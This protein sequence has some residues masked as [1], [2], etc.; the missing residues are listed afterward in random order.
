M[1][2]YTTHQSYRTTHGNVILSNNKI[3]LGINPLGVIGTTSE[4]IDNVT[5]Q[6]LHDS[7]NIV[8][9]LSGG[10]LAGEGPSESIEYKQAV[11]LV[12]LDSTLD[13]DGTGVLPDYT[14]PGDPEETFV[15][16]YFRNDISYNAISTR[17]ED[18]N[19]HFSTFNT[20]DLTSASKLSAK[21]VGN[22]IEDFNSLDN[23]Y[24]IVVTKFDLSGNLIWMNNDPSLNTYLEDSERPEF[25]IDNSGNIIV[26]YETDGGNI[27]G[28]TNI[29]DNNDIIIF[30]LNQNGSLIWIK[31]DPSWNSSDSDYRPSV[32][33]DENNNIYFT[34]HTYGDVGDNT[35]AGYADL[36]L[37][38]LNSDGDLIWTKQ[39]NLL[40]TY[41]DDIEPKIVIDNSQNIVMV[42]YTNAEITG[43]SYLGNYDIVIQKIDNN[44]NVLWS[45]QDI[46]LNSNDY[47]ENPYVAIDSNNNIFLTY[48]TY[49]EITEQTSKGG[50][51]IV[52]VKL[53]TNGNTEWVKQDLSFNTF[54]YD[55]RPSICIDNSD[56]IVIA[57]YTGENIDGGTNKG[58]D[59][60]VV[61][62]LNQNGDLIWIKQDLSFNT[63]HGD[64][65]PSVCVD[66][67]NNVYVTFSTYGQVIGGIHFFQDEPRDVA[68][69]KLDSNGNYLF[70][71]QSSEW[72]S[73]YET[74]RYSKIRF[75]NN[76]IYMVFQ[77]RG[78][79]NLIET[80]SDCIKTEITYSLAPL[81]TVIK[82]EVKLT[83]LFAQ[84]LN[85]VRFMRT[86]DNE[87][88]NN[89]TNGSG[90][91]NKI[92]LVQNGLDIS[93]NSSP[94]FSQLLARESYGPAIPPIT[95]TSFD[96]RSAVYYNSYTNNSY[97]SIFEDPNTNFPAGTSVE[98]DYQN[99]TIL[100]RLGNLAAG[101]SVC[102]RYYLSLGEDNDIRSQ[103][104]NEESEASCIGDPFIKPL[105]GPSYYLPND[106]KTHLLFDNNDNLQIYTKTW[107][108]PDSKF[109]DMSFM[110]NLIINYNNLVSCYDLELNT[111]VDKN[112][113]PIKKF[114]PNFIVSNEKFTDFINDYRNN[115]LKISSNN[116]QLTF[117]FNINSKYMVN[118][119]INCD[120][121][122]VDL[123]N[124]VNIE[125]SGDIST[126][127]IY[128]FNGAFISQKKQKIISVPELI[129]LN[130]KNIIPKIVKSKQVFKKVI[131]RN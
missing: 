26:V 58:S 44:G 103:L 22:T 104:L 72:N 93:G 115:K 76:A 16:S 64:S 126:E 66:N 81:N 60:I 79:Y 53:D 55:Y 127:D 75:Y 17:G 73:P 13:V 45:K 91:S 11:G 125:L 51:E 14:L 111:F 18:L 46:S 29:N 48:F 38:K 106:E 61:F 63:Y 74:D 124:N 52:V 24:K 87:N 97:G 5:G 122:Y 27:P 118:L 112:Y 15:V 116:R 113:L 100:F 20:T 3:L 120:K 99:M 43:G 109:K 68:F 110:K 49:G 86:F 101:E 8:F 69:F 42:Y 77:S 128:K 33:V 130:K 57:Y 59:D 50:S 1:P 25:I 117:I 70:S 96:N 2:N 41:D 92:I 56:N 30:K 84:T 67:N 47:E 78:V 94:Y 10:E 90:D 4:L 36:V 108:A 62:K 21:F 9:D 89:L 85:D 65:Y 83:N 119:F 123:R 34:F 102:F 37:V 28:G 98:E 31:Q 95:F 6:I 121:K 7:N 23:D 54:G 105:F 35:N 129:K 114:I 32:A 19:F 107:F 88:N 12:Y 71:K 82:V 40:N 39:N 131:F 80:T